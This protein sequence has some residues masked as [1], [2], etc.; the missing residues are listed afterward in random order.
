MLDHFF[1]SP[2]FSTSLLASPI[3]ILLSEALRV[4]RHSKQ[5]QIKIYKYAKA[6]V[7]FFSFGNDSFK[8]KEVMSNKK[9]NCTIF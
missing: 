5:D 7:G 6:L 8:K 4:L 1:P 3:L 9:G 2:N